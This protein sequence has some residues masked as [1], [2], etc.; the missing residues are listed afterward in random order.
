MGKPWLVRQIYLVRCPSE[1]LIH[2][3]AEISVANNEL[4]AR[5]FFDSLPNTAN[6]RLGKI[7]YIFISLRPMLS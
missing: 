5:V 1:T 4:T 2:R 3:P 7:P 6:P